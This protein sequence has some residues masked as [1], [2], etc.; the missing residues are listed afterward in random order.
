MA[1]S[2]IIPEKKTK[3]V[4][5]TITTP[6]WILVHDG[7][8]IISFREMSTGTLQTI[9]KVFVADTEAEAQAEV[10]ALKLTPTTIKK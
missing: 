9:Q 2:Y 6:V 4:K 3:I 1:A 7:K 10:D 5:F 8:Q